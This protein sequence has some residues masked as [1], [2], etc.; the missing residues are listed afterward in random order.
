MS[1]AAA[2]APAS[3]SLAEL[4]ALLRPDRRQLAVCAAFTALSVATAVLVAPSLGRVVDIISKGTA[5]TPAELAAAVGRLGAVYICSNISLAVQVGWAGRAWP[6]ARNC[7]RRS[8]SS[9]GHAEHDGRG[10]LSLLPSC[11]LP[12]DAHRWRWRWH[13]ARAW[14]TGCAAACLARCCSVT[15]CSLTA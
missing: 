14:R 10:W 1:P 5:G 9:S 3:L 4:W 13:W 2:S 15:R 6:G 12:R 7:W 8:A 11:F